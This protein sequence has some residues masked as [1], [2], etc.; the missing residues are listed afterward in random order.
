MTKIKELHQNSNLSCFNIDRALEIALDD[1][2]IFQ[3]DQEIEYAQEANEEIIVEIERLGRES[4][5]SSNS[6]WIILTTYIF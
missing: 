3:E 5:E 2:E 4:S 6:V 1:N